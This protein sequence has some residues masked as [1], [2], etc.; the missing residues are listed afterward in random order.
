[1]PGFR[2]KRGYGRRTRKGYGRRTRKG[3]RMTFYKRVKRVV[4][5][6]EETKFFCS[7]TS[8]ALNCTTPIATLLNGPDR[9]AQRD[10]RVGNQ[11]ILTEISCNVLVTPVAPVA[12]RM[13]VTVVC[14]RQANGAAALLTGL[15]FCDPAV[16]NNYYSMFSPVYVP[17]RYEILH[18]K[19]LICGVEGGATDIPKRVTHRFRLRKRVQK[20]I[21]FND[22]VGASNPLAIQKNAIWFLFTTDAIALTPTP[23]VASF[24]WIVKWKDS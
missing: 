1:M 5:R 2:R 22:L 16:C 7:A 18:D 15:L 3:T 11:I 10:Q 17:S 9:G 6:Q 23:P 12:V 4:N 21:Q 20:T 14:D 24:E 8:G 13:R 19:I